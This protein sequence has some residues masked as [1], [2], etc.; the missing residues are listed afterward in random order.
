[1]SDS[2]SA[3][4][5]S[6]DEFLDDPFFEDVYLDGWLHRKQPGY[7]KTSLAKKWKKRW[8]RPF[9]QFLIF[10]A[11]KDG[12]DNVANRIDL[13]DVDRIKLGSKETDFNIEILGEEPIILRADSLAGAKKW[14]SKLNKRMALFEDKIDFLAAKDDEME[15]YIRMVTGKSPKN[16][17]QRG[18]KSDENLL[19]VESDDDAGFDEIDPEPEVGQYWK[20][21]KD[22]LHIRT[23]P[24]GREVNKQGLKE[25]EILTEEGRMLY[26]LRAFMLDVVVAWHCIPPPNDELFLC[27]RVATDTKVEF[28]L[29]LNTQAV[30]ILSGLSSRIEKPVTES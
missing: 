1:M 25:G 28:G 17:K 29:S 5:D 23:E 30:K 26:V 21:Q 9:N 18:A 10:S 11:V 19:G 14:V 12:D 6:D 7:T 3:F 13:R 15:D 16:S 4:D 2:D 22:G 20:A 24:G 27:C 8:F